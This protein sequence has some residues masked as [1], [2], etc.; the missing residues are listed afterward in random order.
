MSTN[1]PLDQPTGRQGM[2]AL[3]EIARIVQQQLQADG[4]SADQARQL[5][6]KAADQVRQ[7]YGGTEV[8]I[9]KG[10]AL[11]LSERDLQIWA[12]FNGDNY[13]A[14]AKKYQRTERQIRYIITRVRDERDARMQLGLFHEG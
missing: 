13:A 4:L 11:V 9:P 6:L 5:A 12:E 10:L 2:E 1:Q 8:Y 7:I 3:L 14:L